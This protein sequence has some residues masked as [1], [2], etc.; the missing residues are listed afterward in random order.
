M[1]AVCL[2]MGKSELYD[3]SEGQSHIFFKLY[4]EVSLKYVFNIDLKPLFEAKILLY[5][6]YVS[7]RT[8]FKTGVRW[9]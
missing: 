9:K 5:V 4:F 6:L 3:S 8:T 7:P 1:V 2:I